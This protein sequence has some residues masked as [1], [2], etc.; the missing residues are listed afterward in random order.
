VVAHDGATGENKQHD[1]VEVTDPKTKEKKQTCPLYAGLTCDEHKAMRHD[2]SSPPEGWGKVD[3]PG[4]HPNSWMIGPDGV[5]EQLPAKDQQVAKTVQDDL[6]AFQKKYEAKPIPWKAYEKLKKAIADGDAAL[7][8]GKWKDALASYLKVD[9]DAAGKKST[10]LMEKVKA[11]ATAVNEKVAAK[12]AEVRDGE[13]S[14]PDKA[15]ALKALRADVGA[16]FSFGAIAVVADLD[17]WLKEAAAA[18]TPAK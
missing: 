3:V 13:L 12:F 10:H 2:I 6:T 18:A 5:V 8:A 9:S 15:K 17:A 7:E 11:K 16:K 1:P 4:G 14:A